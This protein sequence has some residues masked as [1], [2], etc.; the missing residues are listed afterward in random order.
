MNERNNEAAFFR[1]KA[2]H[3]VFDLNENLEK[4][5]LRQIGGRDDFYISVPVDR[6]RTLNETTNEANFSRQIAHPFVFE[7]HQKTK[8][9]RK[10]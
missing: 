2:D 1:Q 6:E 4:Q 9:T 10:R 3:F 8:V 5:N 7:I